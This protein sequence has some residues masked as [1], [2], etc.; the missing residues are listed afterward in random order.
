MDYFYS[1]EWILLKI[2]DESKLGTFCVYSIRLICKLKETE[3]NRCYQLENLC[4]KFPVIAFSQP[5]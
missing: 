4:I 3:I 2:F 1:D 5:L